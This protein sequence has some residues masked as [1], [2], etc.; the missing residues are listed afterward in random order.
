[1][2]EG[3]FSILTT[4]VGMVAGA[5]A[6]VSGFAIGSLLTPLLSVQLGTKLA[7]AAVSIPH[8]FGTALRFW[9]LRK[10][11][12]RR[13][14][15][16]FGFTSAAGGLLGALLHV[17]FASPLLSLVLATLLVFAGVMG[18]MG[19]S[20]RLEFRGK[21]AWIAGALSGI[22]GGLVGNQGGI[23]SAAMLGLNVQRETFVATAT[24]IALMVDGARMPVYV[25]SEAHQLAQEW[26]LITAATAG[27]LIGTIGGG[28]VLKRIPEK[29]FQRVV[30]AL[31]LAL[32]IW[33][34]FHI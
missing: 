17:Q 6:A 27:V 28:S 33:M 18:L 2:E 32:G 22:F 4:I 29:L 23:R 19:W 21:G 14:L 11:V 25:F 3:A 10:H 20:Q 9:L 15:L 5:I 26:F 16:S 31:I 8:L 1:M 24:A 13:I 12:D 7:V 30:A 34:F